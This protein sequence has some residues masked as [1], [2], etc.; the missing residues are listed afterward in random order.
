MLQKISEIYKDS[1]IQKSILWINRL[2]ILV[3]LAPFIAAFIFSAIAW[4]I[5]PDQIRSKKN[6]TEARKDVVQITAQILVGLSVTYGGYLAWQRLEVSREDQINDRY[7]RAIDQLGSEH[8]E[9]RLG[10][11]Y[12]LERLANDSLKDQETVMKVLTAFVRQNASSQVTVQ[13]SRDESSEKDT[14]ISANQ[15]DV[16]T[17][18]KTTPK[19]DI[20]AILT[21]IGKHEWKVTGRI[22]LSGTNLSRANLRGTNLSR[23]NLRGTNLS[24]ANLSRANLSRADLSRANLSWADLR[25]ANLRWADLGWANLYGADLR[26][27]NLSWANLTEA[28]NMSPDQIK[29]A[30]N[31]EQAIYSDNFKIQLGLSPQPEESEENPK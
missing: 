14:E 18:E 5:D 26:G 21:V 30:K 11:I 16:N 23:A 17:S 7:T 25:G 28:K 10:G 2:P 24:R 27:A 9:I 8:L 31:W 19:T 29:K 1:A 3:K 15:G 20:Q 22:D 4:Y 6:T 12:A 13:A